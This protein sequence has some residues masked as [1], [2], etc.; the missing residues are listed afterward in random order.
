M[1]S[2]LNNR[3]FGVSNTLGLRWRTHEGSAKARE[4]VVNEV[5]E[6]LEHRRCS[7]CGESAIRNSSEAPARTGSEC[8]AQ[9]AST[10]E[11]RS[12]E[13]ATEQDRL[14]VDE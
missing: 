3:R 8:E 4:V 1:F 11:R 12:R 10:G 14:P 5:N 9:R 6:V 13:P 2:N 7:G